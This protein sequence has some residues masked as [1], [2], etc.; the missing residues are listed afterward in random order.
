MSDFFNK[1]QLFFNK[2]EFEVSLKL[3]KALMSRF[4]LML[5]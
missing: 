2:N 3:K 4:P 1:K 5:F